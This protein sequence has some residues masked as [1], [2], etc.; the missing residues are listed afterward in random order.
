MRDSLAASLAALPREDLEAI[1]RRRPEVRPLLTSKRRDLVTL[2][3]ILGRAEGVRAA[4]GALDAFLRTVLYTAIWVYPTVTLEALAQQ[5]PG[6]DPQALAGAAEELERWGL[7]FRTH[8]PT[9]AGAKPAPAPGGNW[10]LHLPAGLIAAI[11]MPPGLGPRVSYL[12]GTK[13]AAFLNK[14]AANLGLSIPPGTPKG[15]LLERVVT[16]LADPDV[17]SATL[18]QAPEDAAE[19][20]AWVRQTGRTVSWSEVVAG[21]FA[22]WGEARWSEKRAPTRP[23]EWLE[24][25]GLLVG[26]PGG[27]GPAPVGIPAE[28]E[29][30]LRGGRVFTRWPSAT[31]PPLAP[32][33]RRKP[34]SPAMTA[35]DP[36]KILADMEALLDL[37]GQAP[38]PSVQKGGLGV[39]ELRKAAKALGFPENYLSFLYAACLQADFVAVDGQGRIVATP[40]ARAWAAQPSPA[41]WSLLFDAYLQGQVWLESAGGLVDMDKV[42]P[43]ASLISLRRSLV[44]DLAEL[45]PDL[46]TNVQSLGRRLAWRHPGLVHCENCGAKLVTLMAEA[47]CWLGTLAGPD[48]IRL[49]E[50]AR[51]AFGQPGWE[52][53]GGSAAA[54]FPAAVS[55]CTVGADLTIIVPGPPVPELS[56]G[57]CR[58]ADLKASSPARVYRLSDASL[59]RA[60]DAGMKAAE[61]TALLQRYAP[62]GIPQN[63]AYLIADV[64]ARH[65]NLVAGFAGL[66]LRSEDPALLAGVVVD[67]RLEAFS[68]RLLAPTVAAFSGEDLSGFLGALRSAGYLPVAEGGG[69]A[70]ASP[71]PSTLRRVLPAHVRRLAGTTPEPGLSHP[72]AEALAEVI[73]QGGS[74]PLTLALDPA[75]AAAEVPSGVTVAPGPIYTNPVAIRALLSLAIEEG[76]VVEIAYGGAKGPTMWL[77]EPSDMDAL[78]LFAWCRRTA[79]DKVFHLTRVLS[80]RAT[81]ETVDDED[82]D[83]DIDLEDSLAILRRLGLF[84]N[85]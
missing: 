24:S 41:R 25:R 47:L 49:L 3:E 12:C 60:L 26:V 52:S 66:Y 7:A 65:G 28:V 14:V 56:A 61:I 21:G 23:V 20:M 6:V 4:V 62:R 74:G 43:Q 68:P 36:S 81:G 16:G 15:A 69:A 17:V 67:R 44:A 35:G 48:E 59:R 82:E 77:I 73:A 22:T 76:Q 18:A 80:A 9:P 78:R 50:P 42:G 39:R 53:A 34:K 51:S 84:R 31:P 33:G 45:A 64:A 29:V 79:S 2:A 1:L 63:V 32:N 37:W 55:E 13:S 72:E 54:A 57:L 46:T 70:L 40:A 11:G 19:L 71:A 8:R 10:S 58:F 5:A 85:P 27:F 30:A 38:P 83:E 75:P